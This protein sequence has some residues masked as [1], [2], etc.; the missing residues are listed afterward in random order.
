MI[1]CDNNNI[2]II[3]GVIGYGNAEGITDWRIQN[4]SS[5]VFNILNS[6]SATA[7]LSIID[8]GN[9]GI[10]TTPSIS[11]SKFDIN[12]NV[13]CSGIY[14]KNNRDVLNDTSNYVLSTSNIL[15]SR[16]LTDSVINGLM[17]QKE[18]IIHL[19]LKVY[20]ILLFHLRKQQ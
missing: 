20:Q 7:R 18:Y 16:I 10:R 4:T 17:Y 5:G 2:D 15:V 9:I 13:S 6:S 1:I 3:Q 8:N 11:S 14:K 19:L 12:G